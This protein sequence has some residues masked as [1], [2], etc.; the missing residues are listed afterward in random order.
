MLSHLGHK[1]IDTCDDLGGINSLN[2]PALLKF[3][4]GVPADVNQIVFAV[5]DEV[6][7][8]SLGS[9]PFLLLRVG[10]HYDI[11]LSKQYCDKNPNL[12]S[13]SNGRGFLLLNL[14]LPLSEV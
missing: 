11:R 3:L 5:W 12:A 7:L 13:P 10:V 6:L 4:S 14:V 2:F 9:L 1:N 8:M